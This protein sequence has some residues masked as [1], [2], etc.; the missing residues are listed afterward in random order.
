MFPVPPERLS[1]GR[2]TNISSL[3]AK[4]FGTI[5]KRHHVPVHG[6]GTSAH[7]DATP[8]AAKDLVIK[9]VSS[10]IIIIYT[11]AEETEMISLANGLKNVFY[12]R[13]GRDINSPHYAEML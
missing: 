12:F 8:C 9:H 4:G 2:N 7:T 11:F 5:K 6:D 3:F 13:G 1:Q 10:C